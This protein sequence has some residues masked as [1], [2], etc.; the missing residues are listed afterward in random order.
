LDEALRVAGA[1]G[2]QALLASIALA[3]AETAWLAGDLALA[4]VEGRRALDF[5]EA[6]GNPWAIGGAACWLWRSSGLDRPL[7]RVAE[8]FAQEIDGDW[9]GAASCWQELGYPYHAALA[10]AG[11]PDEDPL[12]RALKLS[13]ELGA[14]PLAARINRRLRM[15]GARNIPR[16]PRGDKRDHPAGLTAR[17]VEVLSLLSA[18]LRNADIAD[19]LV[20]SARTVDHH[21]CAILSKLGVRSRT[22]AAREAARRGIA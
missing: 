12:R 18:G 19:Q 10:L 13:Q 15:L 1:L 5:Y 7:S 4:R 3:R 6:V 21:V 2:D 11:A 8:P 17:E 22:E 16:G 9:L 20:I 14:R